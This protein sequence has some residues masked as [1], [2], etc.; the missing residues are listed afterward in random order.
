MNSPVFSIADTTTTRAVACV[1]QS[2]LFQHPLLEDAPTNLST[3]ASREQAG[4][5]AQ[6][7]ALC[8]S[9][10]A[11]SQC[12]YDAVVKYDVAGIVAGTTAV[13]RR[14]VRARL[15]WRVEAENFDVL[16]GT[17]SGSHVDHV[18]V[19]RAHRANPQESLAQ[20]AERLGCSLSTVKRHL[21]QE[22]VAA[23][24]ALRVLPPSRELVDQ[25][26]RDLNLASRPDEL[27]VA[28]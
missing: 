5:M 8:A 16:L 20:L 14:A 7:S 22:R 27:L 25:A 10:P 13:E 4:L 18:N 24:P 21:R 15:G 26:L 23:R 17:S 1:D 2:A 12:L 9:C 11:R 3:A 19:V 6:A 28:A